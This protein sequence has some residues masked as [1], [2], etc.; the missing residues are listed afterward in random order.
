MPETIDHDWTR[1]WRAPDRALEAMHAGFRRHTYR[2]HSHETYSFGVTETGAQAFRCRGATRT[3]TA[4]MVMTFN[5]D[6]PH[7]GHPVD[8]DGFVYRIVHIGPG[9]VADVLGDASGSADGTAGTA[10]LPLF[11]EPVVDDPRLAYAL[12]RLH[13][14]LIGGAGPLVRDE[15][16]TAAVLAL[17][18]GA[19]RRTPAVRGSAG[20]RAIAARACAA[21][22][23]GL[24]AV[25]GTELAAAAGCS[26][27]ALYR[28]FQEVHGMA[29]SDYHRQLRLREARRLLSGGKPI[30]EAAA[31][32]GFT[33]QA[34]LTRWFVRCYGV[35]P[36][37][38]VRAG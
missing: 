33:D 31:R 7:D 11:P 2:P 15:R 22:A 6:E 35:T 21:L 28:A 20:A 24:D 19:A 36:A 27:Y 38:Y 17:T 1:Y 5:P 8:D 32:A 14:A 3:S 18:R 12:R 25:D 23:D 34:H 13:A 10:G 30:A 37:A 9:L 26:R 29:P 4:G 16:L